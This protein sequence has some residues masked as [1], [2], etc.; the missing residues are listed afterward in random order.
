MAY[1]SLAAVILTVPIVAQIIPTTT[2]IDT[3]EGVA[4]WLSEH[5]VNVDYEYDLT[6]TK[7]LVNVD[8][9][10]TSES[11]FLTYA[12]G[13][14]NYKIIKINNQIVLSPK[15]D[16]APVTTQVLGTRIAEFSADDKS[17]EEI[18]ALISRA[19]ELHIDVDHSTVASRRIIAHFEVKNCT[20]REALCD[21]IMASKARFWTVYPTLSR[22][23]GGPPKVIVTAVS[24]Y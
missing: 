2:R 6:P 8:P 12:C 4:G 5:G 22:V 16:S 7:H 10:E 1:L 23:N 24:I 21:L 18:I 20:V 19:K 14:F 9:A 11:A 13:L 17:V 3:M 15:N